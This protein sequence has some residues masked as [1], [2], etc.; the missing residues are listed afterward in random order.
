MTGSRKIFLCLG[1]L[2]GHKGAKQAEEGKKDNLKLKYIATY[3][4]VLATLLATTW[5]LYKMQIRNL[6]SL[7]GSMI[8]LSDFFC[9]ERT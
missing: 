1:S 7:G 3:T 2:D 8:Y 4:Y 5:F 6:Q 9:D